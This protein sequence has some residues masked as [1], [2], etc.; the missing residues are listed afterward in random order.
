M[1]IVIDALLVPYFS[2]LENVKVFREALQEDLKEIIP[3]ELGAVE[4]RI[5]Y[6]EELS[7]AGKPIISVEYDWPHERSVACVINAV[8]M[9]RLCAFANFE[10]AMAKCEVINISANC[11]NGKIESL[12]E[13]RNPSG[14]F[15]FY[16]K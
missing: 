13:K 15:D 3:E 2:F 5:R 4:V 7:E 6:P 10:Q 9:G 11:G 8:I 14:R 16:K 12:T 1:A